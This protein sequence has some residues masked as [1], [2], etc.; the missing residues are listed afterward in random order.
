MTFLKSFVFS[1]TE[2]V[3]ITSSASYF[4]I[5]YKGIPKDLM[6]FSSIGICSVRSGGAGS[7]PA[8]Y[9]G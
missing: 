7:R 4:S 1:D 2:T 5:E 3:P 6:T 9:S 8:L